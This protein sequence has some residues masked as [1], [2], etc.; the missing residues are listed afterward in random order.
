MWQIGFVSSNT[1]EQVSMMNTFQGSLTNT[2]VTGEIIVKVEEK[3]EWK[4][5]NI[6]LNVLKNS[7]NAFYTQLNSDRR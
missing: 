4:V 3:S 7:V 2:I 1:G 6:S 5:F